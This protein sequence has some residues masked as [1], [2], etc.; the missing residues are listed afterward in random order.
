MGCLSDFFRSNEVAR[1]SRLD[2]EDP[3]A[4]NNQ[5]SSLVLEFSQA[6][7]KI[8]K[9]FQFIS[10]GTSFI[11]LS[12]L[13]ITVAYHD[14]S[15][16]EIVK[17][18]KAIV[19]LPTTCLFLFF[20]LV[21]GLLIDELVY[22]IKLKDLV[23]DQYQDRLRSVLDGYDFIFN[24]DIGEVSIYEILWILKQCPRGESSIRIESFTQ[25]S[26]HNPSP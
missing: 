19:T 1:L 11:S 17:D 24:G 9:F 20:G 2:N 7:T 10:W 8:L 18:T 3:N 13:M 6:K 21:M 14:G 12:I 15:L 16:E 23:N 5:L 26:V 25:N 22:G 4:I